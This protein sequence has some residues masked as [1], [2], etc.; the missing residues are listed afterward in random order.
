MIIGADTVV[1]DGKN[2]FEKPKD[3]DHA[4][5]MITRYINYDWSYFNHTI[6]FQLVHQNKL[7]KSEMGMNILTK[8]NPFQCVIYTTIM[9]C[10]NSESDIII[11][12]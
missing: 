7:L 9:Q 11:V 10:M 12:T 1:T 5:D 4:V 6:T 3:K 8:N 2:I